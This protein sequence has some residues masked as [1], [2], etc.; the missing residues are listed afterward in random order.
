MAICNSFPRSVLRAS[1]DDLFIGSP[2]LS[3]TFGLGGQLLFP[4]HIGAATVLLDR[5]SPPLLARAI[6][7]YQATVCF[8]APTSYRMMATERDCD[9]STLRKC[10]SAGEAL[11]MATRELWKRRTGLEI[12]DGLGTT[13]MLHIF[14]SMSGEDGAAHRGAVGKAIPGYEIAILD[15]E[16][17]VLPTGKVG[18]LAVKGPT[19]CRYLADGRQ[20]D[21]VNGGWNLTGDMGRLDGHGYFYYQ[22][23]T[24]DLIVSAGYNISP[25]EVEEVMLAHPAV[26]ECSVVGVPHQDRGMIVKASIVLRAGYEPSEEL[27]EELQTFAKGVIAPYKYPRAIEFCAD[28]P[29]TET[30]KVQRFKLR[31]SIDTGEV[32]SV[33]KR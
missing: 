14:V 6:S 20:R 9:F 23:R 26:R 33:P 17:R 28:L 18:R 32:A 31:R 1:S 3:F 21:Y 8:S 10:V 12:I 11:T 4:L 13:E 22:G 15:A 27:I 29:R 2:P 30:G 25:V 16:G 24:D 5:T 19:G 7:E